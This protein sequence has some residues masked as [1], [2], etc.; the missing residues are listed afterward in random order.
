MQG[1]I[2]GG[3]GRGNHRRHKKTLN[4]AIQGFRYLVSSAYVLEMIMTNESAYLSWEVYGD[5]EPGSNSFIQIITHGVMSY[6]FPSV[7]F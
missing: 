5:I 6:D 4:L 2:E 1:C 3:K 7:H